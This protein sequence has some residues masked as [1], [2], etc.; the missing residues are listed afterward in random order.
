MAPLTACRKDDPLN[1]P[2]PRT[3]FFGRSSAKGVRLEVTLE[4]DAVRASARSLEV[5]VALVNDSSREISLS[6]DGGRRIEVVLRDAADGR[7]LGR[8]AD[9]RALN[10]KESSAIV[11]PGERLSFTEKLAV[12]GLSAGRACVVEATVVGRETLRAKREITPR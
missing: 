10:P 4:S 11:N 1:P 6:A 9:T 2:K 12:S 8:A 7:V 3:G 5:T